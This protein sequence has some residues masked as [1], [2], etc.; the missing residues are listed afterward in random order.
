MSLS[1][2]SV[3]SVDS[4]LK[5]KKGFVFTIDAAFALLIFA[6]T[7]MLISHQVFQ[8]PTPRSTYLKQI[9]MDTIT[10][11]GKTDMLGK[12]LGSNS[13]EVRQV[14]DSLPQSV[15]AQVSL[16]SQSGNTTTLTRPGCNN[17]QKEL[18]IIRKPYIYTGNFYTAEIQSWF[19]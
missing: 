13:T 14:L 11:L 6:V 19:E 12:M 3:E 17:Y 4:L 15:C 9:S 7:F 8:D 10:V 16:T 5:Q 18:Q 2:T 1:K